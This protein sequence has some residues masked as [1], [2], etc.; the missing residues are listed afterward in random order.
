[1]NAAT[2]H[3][4]TSVITTL[5]V[6]AAAATLTACS[7]QND[8]GRQATPASA[9]AAQTAGGGKAQ[10]EASGR[11]DAGI[12]RVVTAWAEAWNSSNPQKMA[13]LFTKDGV[14]QDNA[15]QGTMRGTKGVADWVTM[16]AQTIGDAHVEI[17]DAFRDGDRIA[18]RWKFSGTESGD[19]TKE[20]PATGK[21]FTVPAVTIMDL[22]GDKIQHLTDTYNLADLLRQSGL[23]AGAWNPT[24]PEN[25]E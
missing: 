14:Y 10:A 8:P 13:A 19:F 6:T 11:H 1:M 15:F 3:I 4:R 7:G 24:A 22:K 9:G 16:T 20:Y 17:V 12:P 18:V 25:T 5:A 2:R 23:P 21:S